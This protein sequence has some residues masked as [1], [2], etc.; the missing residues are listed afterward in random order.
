MTI[1]IIL[2]TFNERK[3]LARMVRG[4]YKIVPKAT[5]II[6]DDHSPDRTG[7]LAE[8]LAKKFPI[9]VIHRRKKLGLSPAV[10]EGFKHAKTGIVGV[11]D[12]DLSHPPELI[13]ELI[14]PITQGKADLVIGSR[15]VKGGGVEV[16]PFSRRVISRIATALARPL[17][18]VRDPMSGYF[19]L[20]K[21]VLNDVEFSSKGYKILLEILVK[22]KYRTVLEVPYVF[23][24]RSVGQSKLGL[25]QYFSYLL[26]L[27]K[28]YSY[29]MLR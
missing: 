12:A 18:E 26:D 9:K 25:K 22:C 29:K 21:K 27:S 20:R 7:E 16:W 23:R 4:I 19:F 1:T 8:S 10:A 2:P 5:L 24:S 13:P 28:L 6:V 11:M 15:N 3:N 17:T 14:E